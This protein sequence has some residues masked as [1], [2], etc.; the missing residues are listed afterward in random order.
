MSFRRPGNR[1]RR[2]AAP[3]VAKAGGLGELQAAG[4]VDQ[5]DGPVHRE[6]LRDQQVDGEGLQAGAVL[7]RAGH[8][9]GEPAL[10]PG[11]A[12]GTFLDLGVHAALDDLELPAQRGRVHRRHHSASTAMIAAITAW[13]SAGGILR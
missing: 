7:E 8:A 5:G 1:S 9:V 10:G 6:H 4:R 13:R 12:R 2:R 11:P 3:G